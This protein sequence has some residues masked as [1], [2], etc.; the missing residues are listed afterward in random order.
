ME[1]F[2]KAMFTLSADKDPKTYA[3][4]RALFNAIL[5]FYR[6]VLNR[7]LNNTNRLCRH[8]QRKTV[9]VISIRRNVSMTIQTVRQCRSK[10]S[11]RSTV[12][13]I[14][15]GLELKVKRL[16]THSQFELREARAPRYRKRCI[17]AL[18]GE[19]TQIK[20]QLTTKTESHYRIN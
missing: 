10:G 16:L 3:E 19:H 1:H 7:I 12:S 17:Q 4:R 11:F 5:Y 13:Q 6:C 14:V 9:V 15:S 8:L 2:V 20:M 18:L